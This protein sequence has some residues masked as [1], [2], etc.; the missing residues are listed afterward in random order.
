MPKARFRRRQIKT[1]VLELD[2]GKRAGDLSRRYGVSTSTLYRW[3]AHFVQKPQ[4][5]DGERLRVLEGELRWLK[6][7]FAKLTLEYATLGVVLVG[8]VMGD[9]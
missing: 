1:M 9:C 4:L 5:D 7:Q 3:P 6:K 2:A 8:G